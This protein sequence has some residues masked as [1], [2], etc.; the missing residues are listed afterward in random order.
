MDTLGMP[1]GYG[2]NY[3]MVP[4]FGP[5]FCLL[6]I[7]TKIRSLKGELGSRQVQTNWMSGAGSY[8]TTKKLQP[9]AHRQTKEK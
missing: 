8:P 1:L 2:Y 9:N 4:L 7:C 3:I 5:I 6:N